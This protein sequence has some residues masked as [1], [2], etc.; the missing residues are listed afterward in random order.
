MEILFGAIILTGAALFFRR[1]ERIYE[2]AEQGGKLPLH[3]IFLENPRLK[4]AAD[5]CAAYLHQK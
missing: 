1:R 5:S 3:E 4:D 2:E